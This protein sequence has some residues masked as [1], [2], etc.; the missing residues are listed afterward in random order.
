MFRLINYRILK[1]AKLQEVFFKEMVLPLLRSSDKMT[2]YGLLQSF[3]DLVH[4][5]W[6]ERLAL[7]NKLNEK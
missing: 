2:A 6:K 7:E 3:E 5:S 1:L 4:S